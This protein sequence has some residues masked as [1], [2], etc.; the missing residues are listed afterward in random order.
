MFK[1]TAGRRSRALLKSASCGVLLCVSAGPLLA[2]DHQGPRH[3]RVP[4]HYPTI[5]A[6]IDHAA[7]GDTITVAPGTYFERIHYGGRSIVLRSEEGPEE[8]VIDAQYQGL[9]VE[10]GSG[11]DPSTTFEGF[12]VTHGAAVGTSF[13]AGLWADDSSGC[14]RNN[15][16]LRNGLDVCYGVVALRQL[17]HSGV[18]VVDSNRFIDNRAADGPLLSLHGMEVSVLDNEFRHNECY[19]VVRIS[20]GEYVSVLRNVVANNDAIYSVAAYYCGFARVSENWLHR[21]GLG[22]TLDSTRGEVTRNIITNCSSGASLSHIAGARIEHNTIINTY[23]GLHFFYCS[24][25]VRNNII[26]GSEE[27]I[28]WRY[29]TGLLNLQRNNLWENA[30]N[31]AGYG[32]DTSADVYHDP[33]FVDADHFDLRLSPSSPLIDLGFPDGTK[34]RIGP[35]ADI[36]AA[37]FVYDEPATATIELE[38]GQRRLAPGQRVGYE[39]RIAGVTG[40]AGKTVRRDAWIEVTGRRQHQMVALRRGVRLESGA[41]RTIAGEIVVPDNLPAGPYRVIARWGSVDE[42]IEASGIVDVRVVGK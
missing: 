24:G 3:F 40:S 14:V 35:A 9:A 2:L 4:R 10:F 30:A 32:G 21:N 38:L 19:S 34:T 1:A 31:Y 18:G 7:N 27:G 8:T 26:V 11:C 12:T 28:G 15:I 39:L 37:E 20:T 5:Q 6:A 16:F 25:I 23:V 17:D 29:S 42:G 13:T 36:G 41:S 22:I 33:R